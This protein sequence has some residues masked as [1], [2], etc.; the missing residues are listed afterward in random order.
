[1]KITLSM[2]LIGVHSLKES[3]AFYEKALGMKFLEFRPP[4]A[5][6]LLDEKFLFNIEENADYRSKDWAKNHIGGMKSCV[7]ETDDI[8]QFLKGIEEYGGTIISLPVVEPWGYTIATFSDLSG[9]TFIVEQ[10]NKE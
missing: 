4:F 3:R 7:F 6:A 9:N 5:E 10:E 8:E 2:N 1:M